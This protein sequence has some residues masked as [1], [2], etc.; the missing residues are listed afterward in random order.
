[1]VNYP[2]FGV[3]P[4]RTPRP[5]VD[6]PALNGKRVVLSTPE[7]FVRDM[8]AVGEVRT[9]GEGGAVIDILSEAN[10]YEKRFTGRHAEPVSWPAHLVWIE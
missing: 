7:G 9:D 1:V 10:Y 3:P 5:A 2:Y 8:R 4:T 6:E